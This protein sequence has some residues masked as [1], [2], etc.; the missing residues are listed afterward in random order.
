[1]KNLNITKQVLLLLLMIIGGGSLKAQETEY[2]YVP[3]PTE[4]AQWSVANEKYALYGDTIID[5][6][7]YGKI[8]KQT[9]DSL[10]EFDIN[11]AEYFCA[12]RNDVENKRV[13]GIYKEE[14]P[15]CHWG[16]GLEPA[17][18]KE[19]LLY[20][21]S[22][23]VG[24]TVTVVNFDEAELAGYISYVKFVREEVLSIYIFD[25][26]GGYEFLH[27][28]NNDSI[29]KLTNNEQRKRIL[30]RGIND[31][32]DQYW[33]EGIGSSDGPFV[34]NFFDFLEYSPKRLLCYSENDEY[35][36]L[37]EEFDIDANSDCFNP[38]K[39]IVDITENNLD[40][41]IQ[42]YP[43]PTE[44]IVNIEDISNTEYTIVIYNTKGQKQLSK[45]AIGK[46][47]IDIS[48][49]PRGIYIMNINNGAS[50]KN[51]KLIK[52]K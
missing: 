15:I 41:N 18:E 30:M 50:N 22:V 25:G 46:S 19:M 47:N 32:I 12:I 33:I 51:C 2:S 7:K 6:I 26:N 43:N 48:D 8:Y 49:L 27:L 21:F 45:S 9:S 16:Y 35:L 24:D 28:N 39:I 29:V 4:N 5:E 38:R 11:K 34:H 1:M 31:P 42:I 17:S 52:N 14:L 36:Y 3:F 40:T 37:Q 20:D 13:Y 10:F 23:N 44:G